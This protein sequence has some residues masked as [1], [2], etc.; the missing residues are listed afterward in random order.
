[1]C[2]M[3]FFM[4]MRLFQSLFEL[5]VSFPLVRYLSLLSVLL[6]PKLLKHALKFYVVNINVHHT[7]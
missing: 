2:V 5:F 7:H 3:K 4:F 6:K 1:M